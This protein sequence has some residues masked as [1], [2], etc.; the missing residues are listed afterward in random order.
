MRA[1][2][3]YT[4]L[5]LLAV[6]LLGHVLA[7]AAMG[8]S[9][10]PYVHHILGFFIILIVTGAVIWALGRLLWRNHPEITAIAIAAVQAIL[11][12]LVYFDAR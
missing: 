2:T 10:T 5:I 12:L 6:G 8:G 1:T 11:G 9:L 3:K 4:T 7:A